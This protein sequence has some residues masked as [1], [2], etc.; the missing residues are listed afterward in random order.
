MNFQELFVS[1]TQCPLCNARTDN[2]TK[3]YKVKQY[4]WELDVIQCGTC[5]L[6]YKSFFPTA[7]LFGDIYGSQYM[8]FENENIQKQA[9]ELHHRIG[10]IGKP[11]GR[12]LDY[13]CGNG[14]FVLAALKAGWDAYGCDPFLPSPLASSVLSNRCYRR[15]IAKEECKDLGVFNCITM[16]AVS[17]HLFRTRETF[18][19]LFPMVDKDGVFN[20]NSPFGRSK[21]ALES[22][23]QWRMARIVEHLQFHTFKSIEYIA[24]LGNMTVERIRIC[25]SPWPLGSVRSDGSS[26]NKEKGNEQLCGKAEVKP[27][28]EAR[29][30]SL[31]EILFREL[32]TKNR[33]KTKDAISWAINRLKIGDHIEVMLRKK[34]V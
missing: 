33:F 26:H 4:Q 28:G 10:R 34:R 20:F 25:G 1:T 27:F 19:G 24:S 12:L 16:W 8:H 14:S 23:P 6:T 11:I 5:G 3:L 7:K 9:D 32:I 30:T 2:D 31:R 15:D 21:I 13:G 17:E 29:R 18:N 22:G